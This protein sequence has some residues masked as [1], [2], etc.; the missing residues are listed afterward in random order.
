MGMSFQTKSNT[1]P[2][3]LSDSWTNVTYKKSKKK[4]LSSDASVYVPATKNALITSKKNA[5]ITRT[6]SKKNTSIEFPRN[7][8]TVSSNRR[9]IGHLLRNVDFNPKNIHPKVENAYI[10][11][12][13][14]TVH[15]RNIKYGRGT[16][17]D[18]ANE[19]ILSLYTYLNEMVDTSTQ[20]IAAELE[21][22]KRIRKEENKRT[23]KDENKR[24]YKDENKRTYKKTNGDN[25]KAYQHYSPPSRR[26]ACLGDFLFK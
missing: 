24:T 9:V 11:A 14:G 25:R 18:E 1:S 7:T 20:I 12:G 17:L 4:P 22:K 3:N 10:K 6:T 21:E 16:T 19:A 26:G 2:D 15:I 13:D 5:P 8:D 23:Y